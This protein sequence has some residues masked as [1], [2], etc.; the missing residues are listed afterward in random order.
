MGDKQLYMDLNLHVQVPSKCSAGRVRCA[1]WE[2]PAAGDS[3]KGP[4]L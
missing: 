3:L 1:L 4:A 2:A